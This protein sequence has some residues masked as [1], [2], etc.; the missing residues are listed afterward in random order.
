MKTTFEPRGIYYE[1]QMYQ[2]LKEIY[3]YIF[4]EGERTLLIPQQR[5]AR[6]HVIRLRRFVKLS[7]AEAKGTVSIT[8]GILLYSKLNFVFDSFLR[9]S[10][11]V[12]LAWSLG[13]TVHIRTLCS[14][15]SLTWAPL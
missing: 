6:E 3:T 10:L 14:G 9:P 1:Q 11:V 13:I 4:V 7:L 8:I 5:E 15:V 12:L 2:M